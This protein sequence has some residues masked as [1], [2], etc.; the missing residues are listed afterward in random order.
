M[1][2]HKR[3]MYRGVPMMEGWPEKID[4]AQKIDSY[5]LDGK[6]FRRVRYE[7]EHEDWHADRIPCHDCRV[8]KGE[9]HVPGCDVE[10]CPVCGGQL[11]TCDCAFAEESF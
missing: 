9:F 7:S 6:H 1:T 2:E 5:T 10:E 3:I 8:V 4:A 11:I